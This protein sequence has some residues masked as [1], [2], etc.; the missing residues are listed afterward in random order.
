MCCRGRFLLTEQAKSIKKIIGKILVFLFFPIQ[1]N[2]FLR[3]EQKSFFDFNLIFHVLLSLK[4]VNKSVENYKAIN[5]SVHTA[6]KLTSHQLFYTRWIEF[7]ENFEHLWLHAIVHLKL[8]EI[9]IKIFA[10]SQCLLV[11]LNEFNCDNN[12]SQF[13]MKRKNKFSWKGRNENFPQ[14]MDVVNFPLSHTQVNW[15]KL[16]FAPKNL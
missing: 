4:F 8:R 9:L 5:C 2:L 6:S 15:I 3:K 13:L 1:K 7:Y 11:K 16:Q 12:F 14:W 10:I